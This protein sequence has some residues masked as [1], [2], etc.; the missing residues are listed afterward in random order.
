[1]LLRNSWLSESNSRSMNSVKNCFVL[2]F[3][4]SKSLIVNGHLVSNLV[5]SSMNLAVVFSLNLTPTCCCSFAKKATLSYPKKVDLASQWLS[6]SSGVRQLP[7]LNTKRGFKTHFQ[8]KLHAT[9]LLKLR[10]KYEMIVLMQ[11]LSNWLGLILR[12]IPFKKPL[13][14]R[15]QISKPIILNKGWCLCYNFKVSLVSRCNVS[16]CHLVTYVKEV[17]SD[18]AQ[19][20]QINSVFVHGAAQLF[21][22]SDGNFSAL[23]LVAELRNNFFL[24]F[25]VQ[26]ANIFLVVFFFDSLD[27]PRLL[28]TFQKRKYFRSTYLEHG[29]RVA[30]QSRGTL[31]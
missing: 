25:N 6:C 21:A 19:E 15:L 5:G 27:L 17:F 22:V 11:F 30:A 1:M 3:T 10:L 12:R 14:V 13:V 7:N 28:V 31:A 20:S 16:K 26:R 29:E 9:P 23:Q 18:L 24:Q 4:A 2:A 8:Y